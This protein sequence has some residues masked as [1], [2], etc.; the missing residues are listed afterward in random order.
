[1]YKSIISLNG[2]CAST[3]KWRLTDLCNYQCSYCIRKKTVSIDNKKSMS[4]NWDRIVK[5]IPDVARIIKELPGFVKLD[6]IGGE[7]TIFNLHYI[8]EEL[9]KI[10]G[11]KLK[12]INL[13]TNMS[14][15]AD[16][17]NDLTELCHKYNSE[18]GITCSWHYQFCSMD[19]FL[20]KFSQIKSPTNQKGIRVEA[21]SLT[22][23]Q[24][25][26]RTLIERC[27]AAGFSYFIERDMFASID[28]K[29][30]L[31]CE[32]SSTKKDRYKVIDN[33]GHIKMY[34]TRNEFLTSNL[35][36]DKTTVEPCGYYCSRDY[37]YV[38]IEIDKHLGRADETSSCR[39][40]NNLKDFHP[41][42][43][44]AVCVNS[45]CTLCGQISIS[46]DK[47]VLLK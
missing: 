41:L 47:E 22:N 25:E 8:L 39:S 24:P 18:I 32:S 36:S 31:I 2:M 37:D 19:D 23:N 5:T 1:M 26:I 30:K 14:Q 45:V 43:S 13:T 12:R 15:S 21:V 42:K 6:L 3:I 28:D 10:C 16:Y 11:E 44:P 40:T 20:A 27:K 7:C 46:Q 34:K 35:D 29:E 17:Y 9:F 33:E 4:E 38:Y